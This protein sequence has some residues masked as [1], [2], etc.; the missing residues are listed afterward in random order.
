M[1]GENM[2]LG[3]KLVKLKKDM[4]KFDEVKDLYLAFLESTKSKDNKDNFRRFLTTQKNF[5]SVNFDSL[6]NYYLLQSQHQ[7][8]LLYPPMVN[9]RKKNRKPSILKK[10]GLYAT[11]SGAGFGGLLAGI[12]VS[13]MVAGSKYL[14]FIPVTTNWNAT[15]LAALTVGIIAGS[16]VTLA[17]L[18][19]KDVIVK[20]HYARK[21]GTIK[22]DFKGKSSTLEDLIEKVDTTNLD[23]MDLKLKGGFINWIKRT[24]LNVTNRNRIHH[25][26]KC[27]KELVE[28]YVATTC[29]KTIGEEHKTTI[30]KR[31]ANHLSLINGYMQN[32][33]EEQKLFMQ[34]T[35]FDRMI[36]GRKCPKV[37][38]ID[39]YADSE[40]QCAEIFDTA[41][42]KKDYLKRTYKNKGKEARIIF[43]NGLYTPSLWDELNNKFLGQELTDMILPKPKEVNFHQSSRRVHQDEEQVHH[44]EEQVHQDEE[45]RDPNEEQNR[46][47]KPVSKPKKKSN[48]ESHDPNEEQNHEPKP[49]SKSKKQSNDYIAQYILMQTLLEDPYYVR[50]IQANNDYVEDLIKKLIKAIKSGKRIRKISNK[51]VAELFDTAKEDSLDR[52]YDVRQSDDLIY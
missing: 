27:R 6:Y 4:V 19:I 26:M 18:K 3:N 24:A 48:E 1:K 50:E 8:A 30:L 44:E 5:K 46:K 47:P 42:D 17:A 34:P 38:N 13:R 51:G 28:A 35:F 7:E 39:I 29:N 36:R 25:I 33:I 20:A 31:C 32:D 37:E 9:I 22:T 52:K 11:I 16:V 15:M 41:L 21:Y 10:T 40:I 43:K 2:K 23:I 12:R 45:H 14:G 49:V